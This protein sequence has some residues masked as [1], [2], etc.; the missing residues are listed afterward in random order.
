[1]AQ[2][3]AANGSVF[4]EVWILRRLLKMSLERE[5]VPEISIMHIKVSEVEA[6]DNGESLK[7]F[8]FGKVS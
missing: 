1:M 5:A 3:G 8:L 2:V 4:L 6:L 7:D